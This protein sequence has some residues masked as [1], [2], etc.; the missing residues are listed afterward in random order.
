MKS[1]KKANSGKKARWPELE[2]SLR[3]WVLE[4][5]AEGRGLRT[6]QMRLV[7]LGDTSVSSRH[8]ILSRTSTEPQAFEARSAS[9]MMCG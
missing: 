6:V 9:C 8:A 1:T 3:T 5:R 7:R 4:Q 2:R